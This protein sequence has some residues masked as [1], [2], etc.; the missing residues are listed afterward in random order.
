M[1]F[2]VTGSRAGMLTFKGLVKKAQSRSVDVAAAVGGVVLDACPSWAVDLVDFD[3]NV[4]ADLVDE[5]RDPL[6]CRL[7][8]DLPCTPRWRRRSLR[9]FFCGFWFFVGFF[10]PAFRTIRS[11]TCTSAF[12]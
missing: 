6:F 2:R 9:G 5:V 11:R 12:A 3:L 7:C 10:I 4:M 1:T 8:D